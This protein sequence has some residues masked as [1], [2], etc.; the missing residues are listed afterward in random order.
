MRKSRPLKPKSK[1]SKK[2][3]SGFGNAEAK[4]AAQAFRRK[5]KLKNR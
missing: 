3:R 4:A 5:Q 2:I 1:R